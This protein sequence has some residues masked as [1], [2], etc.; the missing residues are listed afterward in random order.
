MWYEDDSNKGKEDMVASFGCG[1]I[2]CMTSK[3][4]KT[5]QMKT[6]QKLSN[7]LPQVVHNFSSDQEAL[8]STAK[9]FID[10]D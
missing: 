7:M 4:M 1:F 5:K 6:K 10:Y 8:R 2:S 3:K 9:L